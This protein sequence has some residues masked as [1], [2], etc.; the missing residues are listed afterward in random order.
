[1]EGIMGNGKG[2]RLFALANATSTYYT[3]LTGNAHV[4][5]AMEAVE[6]KYGTDIYCGEALKSLNQIEDAIKRYREGRPQQYEEE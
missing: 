1:M 5:A 6:D 2:H 4:S 3:A